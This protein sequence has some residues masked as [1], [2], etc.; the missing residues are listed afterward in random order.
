MPWRR[1]VLVL[2]LACVCVH[3]AATTALAQVVDFTQAGRDLK[4]P[5]KIT[6]HIY[7]AVGFGNTFMVLTSEGNVIIDTSLFGM[8]SR[9]HEMLQ[10]ISDAPIKYI[11]LTHGHGD[12]TGGV[13]LWKQDGTQI[14][15]QQ[16]FPAFRAYQERIKGYLNRTAAAQFNFNL[17][18]VNAVANNPAQHVEPTIT[19]DD[20][21]EFELGGVKFE[22]FHTPGETPDGLTVWIP[23]YKAA[24][25]GDNLYDSFPNIYTLRGT[26]PRWPLEYIAS[27]DKVLSLKP[28]LVLPS[29]G[30][31]I[32]GA[33]RVV[34]RVT[35][36]KNAIQYVHDATV[37]GMNEGK[38]VFTLMREIKLPA[39]LDVGEDYGKVSWSVRG[40]Y[41]GYV[42][43]FDRNPASMY[44]DSPNLADGE[45]A[46]LAGG[47]SVVAAKSR[48]KTAAGEAVLGLRLADAALA[49]EPTNRDALEAKILALKNLQEHTR[50][51]IEHA[52]LGY[53]IRTT[54]AQLDAVLPKEESA[55][56]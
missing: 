39:E 22:L 27:L 17:D 9:H 29:H 40:I 7:Q 8:A 25:V 53:G 30:L 14:V 20:K 21:Y 26:T 45:L 52:W 41:E 37:K 18:R 16:N 49:H 36:Y 50:N 51:G 33:D 56:Q 48:E 34:E 13:Y 55:A 4:E 1:N 5:I 6:D 47:A 3:V 24:F 31:P 54:Q 12:H 19:F 2:L 35:K 46:A 15:T 23:E 28:E 32:Q 44:S 10:K 38:D 43:W 11:I 42:G